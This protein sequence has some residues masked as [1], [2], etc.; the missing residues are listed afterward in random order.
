LCRVIMGEGVGLGGGGGGGLG[1]CVFCGVGGWVDGVCWGGGVFG[2]GDLCWCCGGCGGQ[3]PA[4]GCW[5][6]LIVGIFGY[7]GI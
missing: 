7:E 3:P 2:V 5:V 1:C 4:V 6:G